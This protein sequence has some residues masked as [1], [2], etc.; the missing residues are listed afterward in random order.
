[1][2]FRQI[3]GMVNSTRGISMPNSIFKHP[4][5]LNK[6]IPKK[7]LSEDD[8]IVIEEGKSEEKLS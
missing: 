3:D 7:L 1:M 5:P 6:Q 2:L 4:H 8:L